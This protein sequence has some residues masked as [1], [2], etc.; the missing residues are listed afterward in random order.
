MLPNLSVV[1]EFLENVFTNFIFEKLFSHE[2]LVTGRVT[3]TPVTIKRSFLSSY[4][5]KKLF[6]RYNQLRLLPKQF[7][8][9][10]ISCFKSFSLNQYGLQILS[11]V[12]LL[13][14]FDIRGKELNYAKEW[15]LNHYSKS[16]QNS[17]RLQDMCG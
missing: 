1:M 4:K 10:V 6:E 3:A 8:A 2:A 7:F 5:R 12:F 11:G 17:I 14:M 13:E 9:K 16:I 15:L